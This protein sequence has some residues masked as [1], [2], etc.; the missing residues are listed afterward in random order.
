MNGRLFRWH[1]LERF[2]QLIWL[3]VVEIETKKWQPR[4]MRPWKMVRFVTRKEKFDRNEME[5]SHAPLSLPTRHEIS[6]NLDWNFIYFDYFRRWNNWV[7]RRRLHRSKNLCHFAIA[8]WTIFRLI[9]IEISSKLFRSTQ[10]MLQLDQRWE[11]MR[12]ISCEFPVEKDHTAREMERTKLSWA[13]TTINFRFEFCHRKKKV[14]FSSV[15][16]K[17]K[18][19]SFWETSNRS[20]EN[21]N[22]RK[23]K[24]NEFLMDFF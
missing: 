24:N 11:E 19:I 16:G 22:E 18:E 15:S 23:K 7:I 8:F 17:S 4:K 10:K 6:I 1:A 12:A 5:T 20:K 14:H 13:E 21:K 3:S 2:S 9:E